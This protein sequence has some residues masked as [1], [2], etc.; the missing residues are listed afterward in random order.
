MYGLSGFL[1]KLSDDEFDEKDGISHKIIA[2]ILGIFSGGIIGIL[3]THNVDATYIFI[4]ILIGTL[5][6]FKIDGIHHIASLI[7]FLIISFIFKIPNL[8]IFTLLICIIS[9]FID[10]IGNDNKVLYE[11]NKFLKLFFEYRFTMKIAILVLVILG[12][13]NSILGYSIP[14]LSFLSIETL[15]FFLI[16]EISYE[17]ARIIFQKFLK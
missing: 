8:S 9:A 12:M 6:S 7:S 5:F 13:V 11:K 3:A 4:G 16:F 1:M 10:E 14:Y 17:L 15:T 2:I